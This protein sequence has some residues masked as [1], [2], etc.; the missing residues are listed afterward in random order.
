MS[1]KKGPKLENLGKIL[2][3]NVFHVDGGKVR[4]EF[5][6]KFT[7]GANPARYEYVPKNEIW[8][9]SPRGRRGT[10]PVIVH[11]I[12]ETILIRRYKRY[13]ESHEQARQ[14]ALF[15][16]K[17]MR[18]KIANGEIKK[19]DPLTMAEDFL[20]EIFSAV[21]RLRTCLPKRRLRKPLQF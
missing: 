3:F 4:R 2:S 17:A 8:V 7:D 15:I 13:K 16:E 9:E 14:D 1:G 20:Q 10:A 21:W 19:G 12:A 11:E 5:D 18:R 6:R